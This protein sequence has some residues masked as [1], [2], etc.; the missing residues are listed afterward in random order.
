MRSDPKVVIEVPLDG[1]ETLPPVEVIRICAD[2]LH[3]I[4][5]ILATNILEKEGVLYNDKS[6]A[7]LIKK[8]IDD[9]LYWAHKI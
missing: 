1:I 7:K 9:A 4:S 2:A 8:Y 3:Q 5:S 6:A